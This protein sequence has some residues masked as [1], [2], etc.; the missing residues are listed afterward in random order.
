MA[1]TALLGPAAPP[2][3]R[4][5][6]SVALPLLVLAVALAGLGGHPLFDVDEG[7]FAEASRELLASGDWWH[8]TLNGAD[9]FDKPIGIYWLQ[10]L[11]LALFGAS[12]FAV[13]LP[14]ALAAAGW[15]LVLG[16]FAREQGEPLD[17]VRATVLAISSLGVMAMGRAATADACLNLLIT[18]AGLDLWRAV[19]HLD[20]GAW[21]RAALWIG[22]GLLVKGPVALLVPVAAVGVW[23]L[24]RGRA[25]PWRWMLGDAWAALIVLLVAG[26]WYAYALWRHGMAFVNGFLLHHNVAR[27]SGALEGDRKSTRLNSSHSQQS[28][29]PSSA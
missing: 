1:E 14:S 16:R 13:R 28:R 25:A 3:P 21:R 6:A 20:R 18:L 10:A 9:R 23:A 19:S 5:L 24:G 22:L 12:E 2:W 27:F 26:P 8:T 17:G 4:R 7:A 15:A 11:S 29:M